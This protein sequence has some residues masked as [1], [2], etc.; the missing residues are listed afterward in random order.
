MKTQKKMS[1][2][3]KLILL[4]V[5][6]FLIS[7]APLI[8]TISFNWNRYT[9]TTGETV[10]LCIGGILALI[11]IFLISIGKL[12]TPHKKIVWFGIVFIMAYLLQ[13]ILKDLVLLSFMAFLGCMLDLIIFH[14]PIKKLK[15]KILINKTAKETAK[16]I[17]I[18]NSQKGEK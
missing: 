15:E 14:Y 11:F 4:Q 3:K 16:Q 18:I 7:I 13:G 9:E 1:D 6:S 8:I 5:L 17:N 12:P 10:R 2:R